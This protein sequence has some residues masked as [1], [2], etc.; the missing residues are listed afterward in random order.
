MAHPAQGHL[1]PPAAA[2]QA[3]M[4]GS[5]VDRFAGYRRLRRRLESA[6]R[7]GLGS[8]LFRTRPEPGDAVLD[9]SGYDYLGL[10]THPLVRAAARAAIDRY[11]TS[12]SASRIVSGQIGLHAELERRLARFLGTEDCIVLVSGYLT[13]VTVI[14]HLFGRPDLLVHDDGAHN[15]IL[16]GCRL[17]GAERVTYPCGDWAALDRLV[18]PLRPRHRRGLLVAEGVYSM[19]GAIL[20]LPRAVA[21]KQRHDLLLMVDEA[22]SLGVLGRTGR[23]IV[24][25][26][27]L[28][29]D[30][31]D[32]RMGTLSKSLAS[33]GGYIVGDRGLIE[34]LRHLAPGFIFSVGL[35]PPDTAAALAAL[36]VLEQEPERVRQLR[37]RVGLF[38][39]LALEH[40]LPVT[41]DPAAPIASLLVGDGE[42][43]MELSRRLL[44]AGIHVPPVLPPAVANGAARLRFFI[45]LRHGPRAIETAVRQVARA[46]RALDRPMAA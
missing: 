25:Q 11:G 8:L 23:G 35:S 7:H 33:C 41:G 1:R 43:C 13:N 17:A 18:V 37:E 5:V 9:F 3:E 24:E 20:D 42:R 29:P 39:S 21:A 2:E 28:A 4:A 38:R 19:D 36:G 12:V 30:A 32:I 22:H 44:A 15:S 6:A 14:D 40:R 34:Y 31:V 46:W 27:G 26:A 16:T 45:T 10:S